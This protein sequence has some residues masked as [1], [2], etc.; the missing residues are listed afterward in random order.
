MSY[1]EGGVIPGA[2]VRVQFEPDECILYPKAGWRCQRRD[3]LDDGMC[4]FED[5]STETGRRAAL[6]RA[7]ITKSCELTE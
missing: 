3:H 2:P 4:R 6:R 1:S 5:E 7:M